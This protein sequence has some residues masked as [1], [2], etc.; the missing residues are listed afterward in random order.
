ML[1]VM[2]VMVMM[3]MVMVPLPGGGGTDDFYL[4]DCGEYCYAYKTLP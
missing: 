2:M 4:K 1:V 3:T